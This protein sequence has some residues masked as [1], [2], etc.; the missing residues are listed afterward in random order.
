MELGVQ[1]EW[2]NFLFPEDERSKSESIDE[3]DGSE[4]IY[5]KAWDFLEIMLC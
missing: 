4:E 2:I 5:Y 1:S 3:R